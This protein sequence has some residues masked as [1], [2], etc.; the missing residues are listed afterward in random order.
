MI[1]GRI[2][3]MVNFIELKDEVLAILN[4][5]KFDVKFFDYN[6]DW[7]RDWIYAKNS[8]QR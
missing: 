2:V 3:D 8:N 5:N 1:L 7:A 6:E 4:K